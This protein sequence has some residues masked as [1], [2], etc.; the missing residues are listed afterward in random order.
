MVS[1]VYCGHDQSKLEGHKH[2]T[3]ALE[4]DLIYTTVNKRLMSYNSLKD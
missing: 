3:E 2:T 1:L 4:E